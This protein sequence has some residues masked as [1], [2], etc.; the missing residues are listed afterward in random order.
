MVLCM[1]KVCYYKY[2]MF[3]LGLHIIMYDWEEIISLGTTEISHEPRARLEREDDN[4]PRMSWAREQKSFEA[5][6]HIP[7]LY[8]TLKFCNNLL[9]C[10][11]LSKLV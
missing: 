2:C 9:S 5:K 6:S 1:T 11:K 3:F 4:L 8:K 10:L 7:E